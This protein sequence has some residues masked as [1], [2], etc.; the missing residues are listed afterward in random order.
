MTKA[1]KLVAQLEEQASQMEARLRKK[2]ER[3]KTLAG[4]IEELKAQLRKMKKSAFK[5]WQTG[6]PPGPGFY[7]V[8][9]KGGYVKVVELELRRAGLLGGVSWTYLGFANEFNHPFEE[10][11]NI[12]AWA[13][14][15]PEPKEAGE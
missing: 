11:E 13:G 14:P 6:T 7:W 12:V 8:K 1:S 5:T 3:L 4:H 15:I 9:Y 2:D 10:E